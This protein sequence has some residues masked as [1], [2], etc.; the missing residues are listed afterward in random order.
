[1]RAPK[2]SVQVFGIAKKIGK[3]IA[4]IFLRACGR[5]HLKPELSRIFE[6]KGNVCEPRE[7]VLLAGHGKKVELRS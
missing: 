7:S 1:M 6:L 3:F 4:R 2:K 5:V